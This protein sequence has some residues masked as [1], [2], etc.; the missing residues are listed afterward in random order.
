MTDFNPYEAS[1]SI[2]EDSSPEDYQELT[3]R[4]SRLAAKVLDGLVGIGGIGG[5]GIMADTV[6]VKA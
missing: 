4:G 5:I 3:D 1:A 2:V 6:V